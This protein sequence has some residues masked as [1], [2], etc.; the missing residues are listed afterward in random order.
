MPGPYIDIVFDGPPAHESGRFIEVENPEGA[1]VR[2]G[3]W[4]ER[5]DGLW[6]LRI[7]QAPVAED[8]AVEAA[9]ILADGQDATSKAKAHARVGDRDKADDFGK[10]AIGCWAQAQVHATLALVDRLDLIASVIEEY[11]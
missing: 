2:V 3:E 8:H 1:S 10:K 11:E 9:R 4:I 5:E 6:A 7:P